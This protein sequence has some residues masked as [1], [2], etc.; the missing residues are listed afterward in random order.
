[1]GITTTNPY[2]NSFFLQLFC[3][4]NV[5]Y[6]VL[7]IDTQGIANLAYDRYRNPFGDTTGITKFEDLK[8]REGLS[9]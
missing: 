5:N 2:P 7:G 8:L 3:P 9:E 4:E 1:M 6:A